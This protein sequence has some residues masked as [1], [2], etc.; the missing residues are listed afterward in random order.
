MVSYRFD[1]VPAIKYISRDSVVVF[2]R[3]TG[4]HP[5]ALSEVVISKSWQWCVP[6]SSISAA[7]CQVVGVTPGGMAGRPLVH[8]QLDKANT[9]AVY[10]ATINRDDTKLRLPIVKSLVLT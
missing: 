6:G 1:R 8:P 7:H 2:R 3:T 9:V 4:L 10:V 5:L